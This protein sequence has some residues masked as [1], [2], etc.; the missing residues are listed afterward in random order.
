MLTTGK[1]A[2]SLLS[3]S[4]CVFNNRTTTTK[5]KTTERLVVLLFFRPQQSHSNAIKARLLLD[6]IIRERERFNAFKVQS[7]LPQTVVI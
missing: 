6:I 7:R 4:L 1:R 3:L 5:I 2:P